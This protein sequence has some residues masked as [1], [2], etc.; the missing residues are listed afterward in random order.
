MKP[1]KYSVPHYISNSAIYSF[2]SLWA[3]VCVYSMGYTPLWSFILLVSLS[4]IYSV[5]APLSWPSC[6]FGISLSFE[7]LLALLQNKMLRAH[8]MLSLLEA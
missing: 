7:H 4:Q 2:V 6:V 8:L 1:C 3:R 5:Q